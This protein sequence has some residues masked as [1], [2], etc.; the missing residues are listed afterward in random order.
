LIDDCIDNQTDFNAGG[1]RYNWIMPSFVGIA[2][3]VDS[4]YALR[5]LVFESGEYTVKQLKSILDSNFDGN[6]AL[7]ARINGTIPKYGN[8]I[9]DVDKLFAI[10]TEHIISECAKYTSIHSNAAVIP[11]AFCW[12]KHE[13][14][15][16]ATGATP[17]GR[18]CG[19][20]L[21]DGSGPCQGR[22]KNGPT[23]SILSSTKWEHYKMIGGIA[24]NMKFSK[25]SMGTHSADVLKS[26]IKTYIKRG[27]FELQINVTDK[28]TLEKALVN[29][30]EYDDLIVRIGG[31]S[32][33]FT[34]LSPEMQKEVILRTEHKI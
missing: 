22:E 25:M 6:E 13:E 11:S 9:D 33:Y 2:N 31:Y 1:A 16:R 18:T 27:G 23:A 12:V 28:E 3:L 24:V 34:K 5:E 29:P 10:I 21:G 15:G 30:E 8:D 19:F 14:M 26:I 17:D 7:R 32:D 4:L 20:P